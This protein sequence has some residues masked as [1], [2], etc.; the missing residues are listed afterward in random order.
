MK[1]KP[2]SSSMGK[3]VDLFSSLPGNDANLGKSLCKRYGIWGM[4]YHFR[5]LPTVIKVKH[6][7]SNTTI[8][9]RR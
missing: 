3:I 8:D 4:G 5:P 1:C 6:P 9:L 7:E 2:H